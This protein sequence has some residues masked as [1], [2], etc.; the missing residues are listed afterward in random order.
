MAGLSSEE[1]HRIQNLLLESCD[2]L[3]GFRKFNLA[4]SDPLE[5]AER[6]LNHGVTTSQESCLGRRIRIRQV[7]EIALEFTQLVWRENSS[8][9]ITSG[10]LLKTSHLALC[11]GLLLRGLVLGNS[12]LEFR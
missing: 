9:R 12:G 5:S 8:S 2:Q 11:P 6:D 4:S 3:L 7:Q 1:R 10:H